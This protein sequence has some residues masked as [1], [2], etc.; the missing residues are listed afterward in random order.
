[1]A[2]CI[3][4]EGRESLFRSIIGW[5]SIVLEKEWASQPTLLIGGFKSL[6]KLLRVK[7]FLSDWEALVLDHNLVE[8][9]KLKKIHLIDY[10]LMSWWGSDEHSCLGRFLQ[11]IGGLFIFKL[12]LEKTFGPRREHDSFLLKEIFGL[13]KERT[14]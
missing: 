1:M 4:R 6:H 13:E 3:R 11:L 14:W 8:E 7:A 12:S 2:S 9:D 5:K 10:D